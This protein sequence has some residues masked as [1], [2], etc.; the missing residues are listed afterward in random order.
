VSCLTHTTFVAPFLLL[1]ALIMI[2]PIPPSSS[3]HQERLSLLP[4]FPKSL[5]GGVIIAPSLCVAS[6][7]CLSL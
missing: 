4:A 3:P 5:N 2:V 6:R 1:E 7:L